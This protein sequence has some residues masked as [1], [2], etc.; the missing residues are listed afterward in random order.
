MLASEALAAAWREKRT[1]NCL[2]GRKT[3]ERIDLSCFKEEK[4]YTDVF[5]DGE[6][7]PLDEFL[8]NKGFDLEAFK[9][10]E[11]KLIFAEKDIIAGLPVGMIACFFTDIREIQTAGQSSARTGV[12][13]P[14]QFFFAI[15][16]LIF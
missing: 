11:H 13:R 7:W 1:Y 16:L 2:P 5:E 8:L 6:I 10:T 4:T 14:I 9:N 15:L 3:H 12:G